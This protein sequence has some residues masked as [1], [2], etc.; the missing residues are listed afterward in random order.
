[1]PQTPELNSKIAFVNPDRDSYQH[2]T[3]SLEDD[4]DGCESSACKAQLSTR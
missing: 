4:N 1:M 3:Q 2:L